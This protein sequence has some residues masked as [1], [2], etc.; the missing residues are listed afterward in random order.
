MRIVYALCTLPIIAVLAVIVATNVFAPPPATE[1]L[2]GISVMVKGYA[3]DDLS[4][5]RHRLRLTLDLSGP[6]D[7]DQCIG[8]TLD[9]PFGVDGWNLSTGDA[10]DRVLARPRSD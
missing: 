3:I 2:A 9:E 4:N 5:D 1:R 8:F 6:T 10:R 7:I